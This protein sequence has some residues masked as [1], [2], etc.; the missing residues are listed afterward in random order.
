[1]EIQLESGSRAF[2]AKQIFTK[3]L[4][5]RNLENPYPQNLFVTRCFMQMQLL[6]LKD[7]DDWIEAFFPFVHTETITGN[8]HLK[9][10]FPGTISVT[11][12]TLCP[13]F[14]TKH[15]IIIIISPSSKE[16]KK[17]I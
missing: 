7:L 9:A 17:S 4:F 11:R 2:C 6:H 14:L 10:I 5:L 8:E 3:P 13:F 12:L 16:T 1:M 15:A